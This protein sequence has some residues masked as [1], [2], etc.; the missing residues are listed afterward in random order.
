[1][2]VAALSAHDPL[3]SHYEAIE[4]NQ[5]RYELMARAMHEGGVSGDDGPGL[6]SFI[7]GV[8]VVVFAFCL[9]SGIVLFVAHLVKYLAHFF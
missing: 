7:F 2:E 6:L 3:Q 8:A 9:V 1:M 5:Q 4:R